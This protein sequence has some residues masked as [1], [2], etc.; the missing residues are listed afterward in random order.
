MSRFLQNLCTTEVLF[1]D[2]LPH[3]NWITE[4][5]VDL[6]YTLSWCSRQPARLKTLKC[7]YASRGKMLLIE[8]QISSVLM[9]DWGRLKMRC[10]QTIRTMYSTQKGKSTQQ[11]KDVELKTF[12]SLGLLLGT[13]CW[14]SISKFWDVVCSSCCPYIEKLPLQRS[15]LPAYRR[16]T[17]S[18]EFSYPW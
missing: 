13:V 16:I 11:R 17:T 18:K 1:L 2:G 6:L 14:S 7:L 5:F 10:V 3:L 15:V 12:Y 4:D 8:G 9:T